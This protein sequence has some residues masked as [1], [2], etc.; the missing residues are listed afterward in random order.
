MRKSLR[1][2]K[3]VKNVKKVKF[4]NPPKKRKQ[5]SKKVSNDVNARV[6][7]EAVGVGVCVVVGVGVGEIEMGSKN[8]K[9]GVN[10]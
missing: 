7:V 10:G 5:E 6:G 4:N 1:V 9:M 3:N 2:E 8:E